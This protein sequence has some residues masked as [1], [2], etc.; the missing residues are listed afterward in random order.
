MSPIS[1]GGQI[2]G[3]ICSLVGVIIL[4]LPIGIIVSNFSKIVENEKR[5]KR[6]MNLWIIII[7][8]FFV[9]ILYM[10][11]YVLFLKFYVYLNLNKY[12]IYF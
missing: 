3:A 6:F 1:V 11:V 5:E 10:F 2:F 7:I 12:Y 4:A 9:L 8:N